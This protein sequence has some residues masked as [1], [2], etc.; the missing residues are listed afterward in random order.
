MTTPNGRGKGWRARPQ[1]HNTYCPECAEPVY[2][3]GS[4]N[5]SGKIRFWHRTTQRLDCKWHGTDAVGAELEVMCGVPKAR[6]RELKREIIANCGKRKMRYVITSAQNATPIH[7][8]AFQSLLTYCKHTDAKLLV[9]PYRY[10]NP[11]AMWSKKAQHDDWWIAEVLPY[12]IGERVYLNR[13]L[14]LLA[15]IMTQPTAVSPLEGFETITGPQSGIIGHPRLELM[16]VP[17]PQEKLPKIL[18]T[19]GSITKKNYIPS[20][21]GKKGEHHHTFGAC[22]V[23]IEGSQFHIRQINMT[24]DG[25]FCDLLHEYDGKHVRRYARVPALVMGDTHVE[26]VDPGVVKATFTDPDS[27]VKVLRPEHLVWH[28]LHDGTAKNH[29]ERGRTFHDYVRYKD[30][31]SNVEAELRRTFAFVDQVTPADTKNIV[32][33][34]NH[35]DWLREWVENTDPRRDPENVMFWAET[36]LA[37]I[38]SKDTSWT[39]SGVSV[40]DAFAYWGGKLLKVAGQTTFL[41]RSQPYQIRGIEVSYHGHRG[42]QGRPGTREMYGKI[43]VKSIIGHTH[44]PGI[45]SGAY[46]VGTS[47]RLD[48]T[49]AAGQPSAWLH[50]HAVIY[51]NG[52][53]SLINIIDGKWKL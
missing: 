2:R 29:H 33:V 12:L 44:A 30:N 48:L 22:F 13:H 7:E 5:F 3:N 27:I 15:D 46:Q 28:D 18:T 50:T 14:I 36:Y 31:R 40:Q 42:T 41:R 4:S 6:S 23:E 10:K 45:T 11:T 21:A 43:G 34:S 53:R 49:Y 8:N 47:S 39:P 20:K 9:I 32:V 26:V 17:T 16:T 25:S 37:V 19:T 35:N 24:R 52:K 1:E 38:R 51:P